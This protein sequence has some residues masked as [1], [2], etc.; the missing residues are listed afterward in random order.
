MPIDKP[1]PGETKEHYMSYCMGVLKDEFPET[2]Q[3]YAVCMTKWEEKFSSVVNRI[4]EIE[5]KSIKKFAEGVPHYTKD[6][7]L[8]TGP[9]HKGPDGKLMTG[10][11]HTEDSEYLYHK[12]QLKTKP[13]GPS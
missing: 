10:E 3:R 2:P 8:Y 7:K 1:K 6:G 13:L 12:D 4:K 11:T 9:T 5:K